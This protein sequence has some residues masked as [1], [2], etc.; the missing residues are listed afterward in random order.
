[1]RIK[2]ACTLLA[3]ISLDGKFLSTDFSPSLLCHRLLPL[4]AFPVNL[5]TDLPVHL[6]QEDQDQFVRLQPISLKTFKEIIAR[7]HPFFLLGSP[8][9]NKMAL[10]AGVVQRISLL[11]IP[12]FYVERKQCLI[13][14]V[15]WRN[16][17]MKWHLE[18]WR[19]FPEGCACHYNI[20]DP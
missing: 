13:G 9:A 14:E 7:S 20:A 17:K 16:K 11:W 6:D 10:L 3:A 2:A 12:S 1:M 18:C 4:E 8:E 15:D 19:V 5:F